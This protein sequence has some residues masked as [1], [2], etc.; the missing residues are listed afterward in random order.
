MI[1]NLKIESDKSLTDALKQMD[2]VG[3]KLLMVFS[4][5]QFIG[6]LSIGDL[7]RAIIN[8]IDLITH[9]GEI[10]RED[11]VVADEGESIES[12]KSKMLQIRA[13]FMPVV[14]DRREIVKVIFW[15]DLFGSPILPPKKQFHVPVVIMAGGLG[16]RLKP[17]TNVIPKPL[18]PINEKTIIEHI[19]DRFREHGCDSFY[20]SVNYKAELIEYYLDEQNLPYNIVYFKENVPMGTAGSLSLLKG[21][22]KDTFFVSNCDILI[23]E[24]YSEILEYHKRNNNEITIVAALKSYNIPYG[25]IKSGEKGELKELIEKPCF[26]FKIN[27]GMYIL[28]PHLID[29]I[30]NDKFFHITQLIEK[31]KNRRGR[32]GVFPVSEKSWKDIGEWSV[33][34]KELTY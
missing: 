25:T 15:E 9:V 10:L 22:I 11:I 1:E 8:N 14:N 2:V 13:E 30:P 16:S 23:E 18:I 32:V 34:L 28:E 33:Y 27:S 29:E 6:L 3:K 4:R 19:F 26:T 21:K 12:I 17:L 20:I 5:G 24:D 7:Q 31:V